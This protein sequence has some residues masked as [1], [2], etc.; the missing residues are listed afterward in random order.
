MKDPAAKL[1]RGLTEALAL[2]SLRREPKHGYALLK[3]LEQVFGETPNRNRIY[4]LLSRLE[5]QGYI[6]GSEDPDSSRGKRTYRLTDAGRERLDEYEAMPPAFRETF[7]RVW[8]AP[9]Q[10][11]D[12]EDRR[13]EA[14]EEPDAGGEEEGEDPDGPG[15]G[16]DGEDLGD[17]DQT[18]NEAP[19]EAAEAG[20]D[21]DE[22][23]DGGGPD[24][25]DGGPPDEGGGDGGRDGGDGAEDEGGGMD[26]RR[27]PETGKVEM[28]IRGTHWGEVRIELG[29]LDE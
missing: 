29:E 20:D 10:A 12:G 4:P 2:E 1:M 25:P 14:A 5:E 24:E 9:R 8:G 15:D 16:G 28:V 17:G 19:A 21:V 6:E 23:R 7:E 27:N 13:G 3:E 26:L 18:P 22:P 11:G